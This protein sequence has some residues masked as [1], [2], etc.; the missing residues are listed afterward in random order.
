M[1][2]TPGRIE[3]VGVERR[4]AEMP[5]LTRWETFAA[6]DDPLESLRRLRQSKRLQGAHCVTL[7]AHGEYQLLQAEA[8]EVP[9]AERGEALRWR[10][11]EMVDFPVE[12]AGIGVVDI[13][14]APGGRVKQVYVVVANGAALSSRI[15]L[16]Q[17][18]RLPLEVIDVPELAQ[19][20]VA[21]LFEE[22]NRGLAFL[23]FHAHG[24]YLTF[25]HE[26]ELYATRHIDTT[27]AELQAA[28]ASGNTALFERV[29]LDIQRSM[30]NFD[31]HFSFISIS[32]LLLGPLPDEAGFI[33]FLREN[34]FQPV[35]TAD[36]GKVVDLSA[37]PALADPARQAEVLLGLGA[38]LRP[39]AGAGA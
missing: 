7:L 2:Q 35:E 12:N 28:S 21:A 14:P 33:A 1:L 20:N 34:L 29:L 18:A 22:P 32:R 10:I 16:Y 9:P 15:R 13:P 11:K 39:A 6:E 38:G 23:H 8:P 25:T 31:R 3:I 27:V 24:G 5:R 19:R 37:V 4:T 36:L 26:G 30:D 17:D